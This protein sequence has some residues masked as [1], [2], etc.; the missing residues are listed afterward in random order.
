MVGST[1]SEINNM[2]ASGMANAVK[3]LGNTTNSVITTSS[4]GIQGFIKTHDGIPNVILFIINIL[5]IANR[6]LM[7]V[8]PNTNS[9]FLDKYQKLTT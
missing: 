9:A 7:K 5:I 4:L 3:T 6:V 1:G 8:Q 2:I